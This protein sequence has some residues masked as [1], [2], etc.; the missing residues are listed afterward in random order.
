MEKKNAEIMQNAQNVVVKVVDRL[1]FFFFFN[2]QMQAYNMNV[3]YT[4]TTI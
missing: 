4:Y 2:V 1:V 3:N